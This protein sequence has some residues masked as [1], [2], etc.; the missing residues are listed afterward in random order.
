MRRDDVESALDALASEVP[1]PV[2]DAGSLIARGRRRIFRQRLL[3]GGIAAA[4]IATAAGVGAAANR[5][6][7]PRIVAPVPTTPPTSLSPPPEPTATPTPS[8]V[9][10]AV[11]A[12]LAFASAHEGWICD[13]P[14]EYTTDA[15]DTGAAHVNIPTA[16]YPAEGQVP[17]CAAAPGGNAWFVRAS[18]A[19]GRPEIVRIRSG[20][21][22]VEVFPFTPTPAVESISFVDA[23]NGWALAGSDDQHNLYRTRDGG[24]TW[25]LLLRDAPI[26]GSLAFD[27]PDRGWAAAAAGARLVTTTDG[28]RTWREVA[29]PSPAPHRG[30]PL[31]IRGVRVRDDV[32]VVFGGQ[33][34]GNFL[35]PFFDVSTDGGRTWRRSPG[36][37][38]LLKT[39]ANN[40]DAADADH[41]AIG[42]SN[43]LYITDDAGTTWTESAFAGVYQIT[44]I[45]F[46][47]A[48]VAFVS[49]LGDELSQSAVVLKTADG[50]NHWTMVDEQ[51][52][53]GPPGDVA[54][55]PGGIIGCPTRPLTPGLPTNAIAQA[56]LAYVKFPNPSVSGVYRG[57]SGEGDFARIFSFNVGS[58]GPDILDNIWVAYVHGVPNAGPGGSTAR[59]TLAL[60]HYEDGWHVFGRYP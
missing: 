15:F 53:I 51:S 31:S 9:G 58:C 35:T 3:I 20:G 24:A 2:A 36:P 45:A 18:G 11:P 49:G 50:G 46:L 19:P 57:N 55:V 21:D 26:R 47:D 7:T 34:T 8:E 13:D 1:A 32:I 60:A 52:P 4:A 37:R 6:D 59:V 28:G 16:A 27:T 25:S 48:N 56:A 39:L 38:A 44:D 5:D 12:P 30:L 14:F 40:F 43:Y 33:T 41:W 22:D 17:L 29:V 23:D 10:H 54:S 42:W